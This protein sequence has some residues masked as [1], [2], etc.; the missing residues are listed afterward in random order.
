METFPSKPA[1][2]P[3]ELFYTKPPQ[4]PYVEI[5]IVSARQRNKFIAMDDLTESIIMQAR[6]LGGDAVIGL[7]LGEQQMGAAK[8]GSSYIV[9]HDPILQGVVVRWSD[10]K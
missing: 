9:D 5:G 10:S 7:S 6:E 3:I 8:S 1:D 4:R 2:A